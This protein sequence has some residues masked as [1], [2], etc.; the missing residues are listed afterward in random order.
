MDLRIGCQTYTWE[1][2]GDAFTGTPDDMLDAIAAAGYDGAEFTNATIGHYAG[3]PDAFGA[4]L[5]QRG[6]ACAAFA[7]AR[8]GFT[9]PASYEDDLAGALA[10][11]EF[12]HA[13]GVPL[14][15]GG[16]AAV[17]REPYRVHL[18]QAV[19]F[20]CAVAD[21]GRRRGTIVCVHPHSHHGSLVESADEYARLMAA[22]ADSGLM[23]NPDA[24]H[25]ARGGQDV[26]ACFRAHRARIAHVHVKDVDASG[27]WQALGDGTIR[28]TEL[29]GYLAD[30]DYSGWI[31]AE[32]E[33][34]FA[35]QDPDAAIR[36]N[37][38]YLRSLLR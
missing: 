16:P 25:I 2:L 10:A 22:T 27:S 36:R 13:L 5:E 31:V 3:R 14:C 30:T 23:L 4:A 9:D 15:L 38:E 35:R 17:P 6:L 26:L 12:A 18:E 19:R 11:L 33:S 32:E 20:Y 1:M 37:C 29:L 8:N 21:E 7:Y 34:A 28:W 24:G